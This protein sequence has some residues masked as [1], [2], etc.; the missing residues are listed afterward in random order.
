MGVKRELDLTSADNPRVK[1]VAKLREH[2]R[3]RETGLFVAEGL[4]E[5][6]RARA[7]GLR[8][9]ELY[10]SPDMLHGAERGEAEALVAAAGDE[11]A[12][13]ARVG[14]ALMRKMAYTENPPGLLA[15]MEQPAW[16]RASLAEAMGLLKMG[17]EAGK[18]ELWLVA[19]GIEKPGNLGAMLRTADAAG[20]TAVLVADAVVDAFNPNAIRASTGAVFTLP[21][22]GATGEEARHMLR[23]RGVR[24]LAATPDGATPHTRTDMT[25]AVALVIGPEDT[26]LDEAWLKEAAGRVSIP[27]LGRSTDSLNASVAAAVL[28][29]EAR[30][31][32]DKGK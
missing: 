15:V 18:D 30:R 20:V 4:R 9:V 17:A 28:L 6:G 24:L 2:R 14:E 12:I 21:V 1:A 31:Q 11:G 25:G 32:R 7:A 19:V 29:F 16:A 13:T 5:V 22:L 23:G 3:R 26:G 8:V 27:M 10:W